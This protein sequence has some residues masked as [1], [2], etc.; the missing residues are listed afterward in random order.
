MS[1]FVFDELRFNVAQ[2]LRDPLGASRAASFTV[3][4]YRLAPELAA[5]LEETAVA[6]LTGSVKL[7]HTNAGILARGHMSAT[8]TTACARCLELVQVPIDFELEELYVPTLDI[9]TGRALTPEEDDRALWIDEFHILDLTEVLRQ[10]VLIAMPPHVLCRP[11]C[12]GL[13][14]ACGQNLNE[15]AC[16]CQAEADPRWH[17]LADLLKDMNQN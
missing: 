4:L 2:L 9:V 11:N 5:G 14:S 1:Y 8:A 17:A 10:D 6:D 12:R 15:N 7:A 3:N 16:T 13:C